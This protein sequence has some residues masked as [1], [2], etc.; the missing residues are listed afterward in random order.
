MSFG[1]KWKNWGGLR[2]TSCSEADGWLPEAECRKYHPKYFR[3]EWNADHTYCRPHRGDAWWDD[4]SYIAHQ[5]GVDA[6]AMEDWWFREEARQH[7]AARQ[8]QRETREAG[9]RRRGSALPGRKPQKYRRRRIDVDD[10][11]F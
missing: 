5:T 3:F 11:P 9:W 1:R 8:E 6:M 2:G 4:A 10:I 7:E